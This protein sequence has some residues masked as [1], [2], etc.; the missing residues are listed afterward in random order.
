MP[1]HPILDSL[2]DGDA[3]I[4]ESQVGRLS[5]DTF[6]TGED[7]ACQTGDYRRNE[8]PIRDRD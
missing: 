8:T 6:A 1:R 5:L 4:V 7:A 3:C 2:P